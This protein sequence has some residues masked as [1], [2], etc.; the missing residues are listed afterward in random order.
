MLKWFFAVLVALLLSPLE[1]AP[2]RA[3]WCNCGSAIGWAF[4]GQSIGYGFNGDV[5]SGGWGVDRPIFGG[6]WGVEERPIF[7]GGIWMQDYGRGGPYS[8]YYQERPYEFTP[9]GVERRE[10]RRYDRRSYYGGGYYGGGVY[11]PRPMYEGGAVV[12]T[13]RHCYMRAGVR[14]CR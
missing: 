4:P 1:I 9:Y 12:V 6:G 3:Q 10:E 8:G 14:V 7:G 5:W 11:P 2:A 13:R